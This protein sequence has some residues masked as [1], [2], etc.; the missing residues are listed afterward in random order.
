MLLNLRMCL[1][2]AAGW[3]GSAAGC[4]QLPH[5]AGNWLELG[6]CLMTSTSIT[7]ATQLYVSHS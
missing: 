5:T 2:K 6:W 4:A 3:P 7:E 1:L